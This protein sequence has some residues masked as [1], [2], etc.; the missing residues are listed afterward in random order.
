MSEKS[1]QV[2]PV[3]EQDGEIF[4]AETSEAEFFGVYMGRPGNFIWQADEATQAEAM[5]RAYAIAE[6]HGLPPESVYYLGS[7]Q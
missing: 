6:S 4:W 2:R 3:F 1:I 7:E 5:K